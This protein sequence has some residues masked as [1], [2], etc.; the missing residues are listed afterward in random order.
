MQ[1]FCNCILLIDRH[2]GPRT[3]FHKETP[4]GEGIAQCPPNRRDRVQTRKEGTELVKSEDSRARFPQPK[5][6]M[7]CNDPG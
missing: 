6:L 2:R 3:G 7:L 1:A 4:Q 5:P